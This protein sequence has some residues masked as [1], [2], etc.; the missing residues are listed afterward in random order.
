M[1][2]FINIAKD[3]LATAVLNTTEGLY[4]YYAD[5]ING[6]CI[7]SLEDLEDLGRRLAS[8][9]VEAYSRWAAGALWHLRQ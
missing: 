6:Y 7:V 9:D 5:E 2:G 3:H 4:V 1:N 8:G